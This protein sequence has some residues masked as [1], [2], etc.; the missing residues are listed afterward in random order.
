MASTWT[1]LDFEL[2]GAGENLNTWGVPKLNNDL[3][4][5]NYAIAGYV[6][7][8]LTGDYTLTTQRPTVS[9]TASNF[10]GRI[11]MLKFTGSLSSNATITVPSTAM[12]FMVYNATNKSLIITTGAGTTVTVE[13]GDRIPVDCDGSNCLTLSYGSYTLKDYIAQAVL[14]AT[15]SLPAVTGNAGKFVYTDGATSYWKA[16]ASTDLSDYQT[17]ILGVQV[18]LAVAL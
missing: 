16:A 17:A 15:G 14:S 7:I 18:A 5:I 13:T 1:D 8:A 10:T 12:R 11:A 3:T 9:M 2:Q 4:R 6:S